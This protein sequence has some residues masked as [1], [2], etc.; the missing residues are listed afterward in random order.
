MLKWLGAAFLLGGGLFLG[1]GAAEQLHARVRCL[2]ALLGA[3]EW[4]EREL[5]FRRTAMPELMERTARQAGE[6]ARYL[7]ARCRDHLEELGERSF[8]QIWV[9]AL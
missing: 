2:R 9:R 5:S 7:F 4:A 3:V 1:L 6:P 8:G